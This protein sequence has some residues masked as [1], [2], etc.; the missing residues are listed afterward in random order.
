[1]G[2]SVDGQLADGLT[3]DID[4]YALPVPENADEAWKVS[5]FCGAQRHG[6]G[7]RELTVTLLNG[8]GTE[9]GED[10]TAT[11]NETT[12]LAIVGVDLPAS[13]AENRLLVKVSAS[14]PAEDVT[15]R[16]YDCTFGYLPAD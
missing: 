16:S 6:S 9:I 13:P 2:L 7:L 12:D 11:E 4:Y 1:M 5:A 8:D 15:S 10:Y 14:A 3:P